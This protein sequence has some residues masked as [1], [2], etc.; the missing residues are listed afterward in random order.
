[1]VNHLRRTLTTPLTLVLT[2]LAGHVAAGESRSKTAREQASFCEEGGPDDLVLKPL[3][4]PSVIRATVMNTKEGKEAREIASR[5][6]DELDPEKL[7]KGTKV[8]LTDSHELFFVVMG[9]SPM[10]GADNTWF[11]VVR[12]SGKSATILLFAGGNCLDI[13]GTKTLGYRDIVTTWSSASITRTE[14]YK[15]GG[16]S[17]KL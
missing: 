6:G 15:Y 5:N 13:N 4:L 3:P 17:Y 2:L 10:S 14:I 9:Q 7:L 8:H 12:T 16:E 11:W 1:M